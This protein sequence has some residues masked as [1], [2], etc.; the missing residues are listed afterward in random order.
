MN[1]DFMCDQ[2]SMSWDLNVSKK[3]SFSVGYGA[4]KLFRLSGLF[5]MFWHVQ[6]MKS[7]FDGEIIY[8]NTKYIV[9]PE[10]SFGYQDKNWGIDYTNPWIWLNCN[11]FVTLNGTPLENT[12]LDIGGGNPKLAGISLGEKILVKFVYE[13]IEHEF[14]FTH[15]FF[16]KQK[17][18]CKED[19]NYIYWDV[20]VENRTHTLWVNF[21]CDKDSMI[22]VNYVNPH[23]VKNHNNLWNGGYANGNLELTEKKNNLKIVLKGSLGGCEYGRY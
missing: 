5:S 3:L 13:N 22:K 9:K 11:N 10:T 4:S 6:G 23:G 8:N 14:N 19:E 20:Y 7:L 21:K 18:S 12:S 15:I 16:Q 17:W 2:G 1:P